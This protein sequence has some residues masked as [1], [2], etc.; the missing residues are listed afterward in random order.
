MVCATVACI[1]GTALGYHHWSTSINQLERMAE[2]NNIDLTMAF[3]NSIWPTFSPFVN[4]AHELSPEQIRAHPV[5]DQLHRAM[6]GLMAGTPVL[7]VK[8]YDINGLT[9]FST[10]PSQIG[11]DYARNPRFLKAL[12]AESASKLEFRETFG[13]IA[14]PLRD[15]YVLSSYIP[16]RPGKSDVI[17]GVVEIYSDV[18]EFHALVVERGVI[19]IAVVVLTFAAVFGLLLLAVWYAEKSIRRHH[20]RSLELTRNVAVAESSSR[21]KSE[22]MANMSHELRTPLNAIIGLSDLLRS[23]HFGPLGHDEYKEYVGHIHDG[24][25][26]L[27]NIVNDVLDLTEVESGK[28]EIDDEPVSPAAVVGSVCEFLGSEAISRNITLST[29]L[30]PSIPEIWTDQT[31]LR[32]IVLNLLSNALK[33]TPSGGRV[34]VELADAPRSGSV[35]VTVTDTGIGIRPE[36]IPLAIAPF[37]QVDGSLARQHEGTGLGL[38]LSIKLAEAFGGS[39]RIE[40]KPGMGTTVRVILPV[41]G[42]SNAMVDPA[43]YTGERIAA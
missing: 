38:T 21:A 36:D 27:L 20:A 18:T 14:G 25:T 17:E 10:D 6:A 5:T 23:E 3:G 33:F 11:R 28:I 29:D 9:V 15:R 12:R 24:G 41:N 26:R 42:P 40:S 2:G 19:Q 39:L 43:P 22:F 37:G 4:R 34:A 13:A 8:L 7:K 35:V 31:K 1:A 32:Q 16:V 30:S